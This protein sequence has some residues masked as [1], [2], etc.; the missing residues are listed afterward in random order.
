MS[1]HAALIDLDGTL[2]DTVPDITHAINAMLAD[3]DERPLTEA[4]ISTFIGKGTE[5]LVKRVLNHMQPDTEPSATELSHALDLFHRHYQ[6]INGN[7]STTYPGVKEGLEAFKSAGIKLAVV[8]NK[9]A[10]FTLPLLQRT[11]LD[12]YFDHVVSGDTCARKKPDPMPFIYGCELLKVPPQQALAI[13]DSIND[14][15]SARAAGLH[16]VAVP[17]GYNEG[18]SVDTLDVDGVVDTL[19]DAFTWI[20]HHQSQDSLK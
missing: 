19:H 2:L 6:I 13:G 11:G 12:H 14:A 10:Q 15:L 4:L 17:Y 5:N 3:L 7:H 20:Q 18:Q 1:I 9:P 16:V 8:T